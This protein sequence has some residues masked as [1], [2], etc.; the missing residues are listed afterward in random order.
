MTQKN[1]TFAK[2]L[3]SFQYKYD[4][5]T[6]FDDFLTMTMCAVTPKLGTGK[7]H[8]EDLYL[9][10]IKKYKDD[11]L[12]YKF[13]E[14]FATLIQEM[15]ERVNSDAGNDVLGEYYELGFA[16]KK[17]SQFFT[18]WPIC[19]FMAKSVVDIS[20]RH[21]PDRPLNI[22]EPSCG[23]GRML[24]AAAR[25]AGPNH[26]YHAVDKD[27]TCAKMTA[28][29]LF[30]NG[31]FRSEVMWGDPL[32]PEFRLSYQLSFSPIGIFRIEQKE[33]SRLYRMLLYSQDESRKDKS[34][35]TK[36][37]ANIVL[38]SKSG[39]NIDNDMKQGS[40]F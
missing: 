36:Q 30:L 25:E 16:N 34:E 32:L 10:T 35:K 26:E 27:H 13:P 9:E 1:E 39:E 40:L 15:E 31:I 7:S 38:P 11:Q 28:I 37:V 29:N 20:S 5:R 24:L 6:V 23:S 12:R 2:L 3:D 22:L 21:D 18:P 14:M 4:R 19:Q 8:Y 33:K 17:L